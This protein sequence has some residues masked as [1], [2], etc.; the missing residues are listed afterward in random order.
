MS[1]AAAPTVIIEPQSD[2]PDLSVAIS[3]VALILLAVAAISFLA[4]RYLNWAMSPRRFWTRVLFAGALPTCILIGL[5]IALDL[6]RGVDI[7]WAFA[8]L[9][10]IPTE[11]RLM[12]SGMLTAGIGLSWLMARRHDR[13]LL[14]RAEDD[15]SAFR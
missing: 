2:T 15:L 3:A 14:R 9:S 8:N 7:L 11:G 10:R 4:V 1:A 13:R 5:L 6:S 12:L